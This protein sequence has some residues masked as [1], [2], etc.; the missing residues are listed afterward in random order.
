MIMGPTAPGVSPG[1]HDGSVGNRNGLRA[2]T[3]Y[4]LPRCDYIVT[5]IM[6]CPAALVILLGPHDDGVGNKDGLR[7]GAVDLVP[8]CNNDLRTMIIGGPA[9]LVV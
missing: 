5:M 3:V 2:G 9:A 8:P 1:P 6:V 4:L 7:Q